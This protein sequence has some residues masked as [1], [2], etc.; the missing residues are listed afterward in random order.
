MSAYRI[1]A[2]CGFLAFLPLAPACAASQVGIGGAVGEPTAL[3]A[4]AL[5]ALPSHE[6]TVSFQSG[7]GPQTH[8][9][10]GPSLW[11]VIGATAPALDPLV[12]ND[13][14][15]HYVLATASDGY[16]VVYSFGELDP[17]FGNRQ[18]LLAHSERVGGVLQPLG[19]DGVA[20]VTMPGDVK[21]G[22]YVSAVERIEV[23][24][25]GPAVALGGGRATS[26][27][28]SGAVGSAMTFDLAALQALPSTTAT[29]GATTYTG[30]SFWDLLNN[31]TGLQTDPLVKNDLLAMYVVATGS[32][33]YRTVFSL[34]ELSPDFGNQPDLIAYAANGELLGDDGFARLVVPNDA[35][36]G[37]YVSSLV[38]LEVFHAAA[39]PEPAAWASLMAGL[40]VL[41]PAVRRRRL[42]AR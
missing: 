35:K 32:D 38:S 3:D 17:G 37:R 2:L 13:G 18:A 39:V 14:L 11:S 19:G 4:A 16:K 36:R 33:G 8:T 31:V 42:P 24:S 41:L 5:L 40:G 10:A 28:V 20:R 26:F 22:R 30:V 1:A 27:S 15:S 9:Y 34:G 29:V 7:S 6:Q 25:T 12:H 21:G 23:R